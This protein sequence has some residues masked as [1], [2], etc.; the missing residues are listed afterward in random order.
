MGSELARSLWVEALRSGEYQQ[1]RSA[2][3]EGGQYC[4][5]GVACE[6]YQKHVGDLLVEG[7]DQKRYDGEFAGLPDK[8]AEWLD[9]S[10]YGTLNDGCNLVAAND[11]DRLDSTQIADLIES[12]CLAPYK[13]LNV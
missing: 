10:K 5:L 13:G 11:I 2:L 12:G 1:G 7:S 6:V 4:C 3:C 8:V 9:I